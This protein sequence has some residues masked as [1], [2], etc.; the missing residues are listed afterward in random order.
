MRVA[1]GQDDMEQLKRYCIEIRQINGKK[2]YIISQVFLDD[3]LLDADLL[4]SLSVSLDNIQRKI[5]EAKDNPEKV[6]FAFVQHNHVKIEKYAW[7]AVNCYK[8]GDSYYH[9][10]IRDSWLCRE[11]KQIHYG[12]FIMPIDECDPVFYS[13]TDNKYPPLPSVFKKKICHHCGKEL[14]NHFIE[15]FSLI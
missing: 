7:E 8:D 9:V 11:C 5:K 1:I 14:Q 13:G 10:H 2:T 15:T 6:F 12:K 3:V 4:A